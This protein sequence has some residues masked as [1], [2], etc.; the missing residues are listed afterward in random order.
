M[1]SDHVD[2]TTAP[3]DKSTIADDELIHPAHLEPIAVAARTNVSDR[4]V[5]DNQMVHRGGNAA[6]VITVEPIRRAAVDNEIG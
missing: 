3:A 2:P 1:A 4:D 5:L 6:A